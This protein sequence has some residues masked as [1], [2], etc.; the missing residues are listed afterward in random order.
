MA[1]TC[2]R[3]QKYWLAAA[4]TAEWRRRCGPS[5]QRATRSAPGREV[6]GREEVRREAE[7]ARQEDSMSGCRVHLRQYWGGQAGVRKREVVRIQTR[8][9]L[10]LS[11]GLDI[12]VA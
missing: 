10:S 9:L 12:E 8:R 7:E 1:R 3:V 11:L 4:S 6:G 5:L 2:P